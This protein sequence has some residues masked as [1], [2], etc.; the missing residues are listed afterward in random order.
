MIRLRTGSG[1][2]LDPP[3]SFFMAKRNKPEPPPMPPDFVPEPEESLWCAYLMSKGLTLDEVRNADGTPRTDYFA[4]SNR[5]YCRDIWI[6][7]QSCR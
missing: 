7:N 4:N 5:R 2:L 1:V 3:R 6:P